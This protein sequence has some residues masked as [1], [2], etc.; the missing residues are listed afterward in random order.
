MKMIKKLV[1][2]AVTTIPMYGC[3]AG[4]SVAIS[5]DPESLAVAPADS[6]PI[7]VTV[8][9]K[10]PFVVSGS[11]PPYFIGKYRAGFGN[12]WDVTTEERTPLADLMAADISEDLEAL[13]FSIAGGG[14]TLRIAIK[15]WNF[16]G[17][18]NGHLW[19]DIAIGL[20]DADGNELYSGSVEDD[21]GITGT[22]SGIKG[23]V[24]RDI[25]I[26]Y[27]NAIR[28]IIRDNSELISALS[29]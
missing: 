13:G 1:I 25:P 3:V 26:I 20:S 19:Y 2:V 16:D 24:E 4:Q 22:L 7:M 8:I 18:Q 17:W 21:V 15:D 23:G 28:K 9:D 14:R 27:R 10:R 6:T 11:K 12:P 29:R 5:Y